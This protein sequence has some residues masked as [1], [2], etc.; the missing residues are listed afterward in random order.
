MI[1]DLGRVEAG[2]G[3]IRKEGGQEVGAGVGQLVQHERA[4]GDLGQDS[5]KAG[6]SGRLQHAISRRDR[7]SG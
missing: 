5:E 4:A 3:D 7:R 2:D 1:V 6:A